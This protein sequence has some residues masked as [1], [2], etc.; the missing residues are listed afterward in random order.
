MSR[1]TLKSI[2]L[3]PLSIVDT[4]VGRLSGLITMPS[5]IKVVKDNKVITEH[6]DPTQN[7]HDELGNYVARENTLRRN[8]EQGSIPGFDPSQLTEDDTPPVR[9]GNTKMQDYRAK[10]ESIINKAKTE[11]RMLSDNEQRRLKSLKGRHERQY[12]KNK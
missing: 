12:Q 4:S 1:S 8:V 10:G 11:G 7:W 5:P 2:E 6:R 9:P 3:K